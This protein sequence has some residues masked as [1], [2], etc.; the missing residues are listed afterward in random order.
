[1]NH[2][3]EWLSEILVVQVQDSIDR[4]RNISENEAVLSINDGLNFNEDMR[5]AADYILRIENNL[6]L[7]PDK[8]YFVG[9]LLTKEQRIVA[10]PST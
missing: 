7:C 3:L 9:A 10:Y 5:A 4:I 8:K 1:M 2:N 6:P